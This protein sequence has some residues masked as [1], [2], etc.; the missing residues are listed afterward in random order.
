MAGIARLKKELTEIEKNAASSGVTAAPANGNM[1]QWQGKLKGPSG[2]AYEGGE[3]VVD[4]V[5]PNDYPFSP[6]K[7]KFVTR[8]YH[9]NISSQTGAICLDTLGKEWSPAL[10]IRTALLS[11]AALLSAPEPND[12]QDAVVASQY[13]RDR[14]AFE[15]TARSWAEMYAGAPPRAGGGSSSSAS[16]SSSNRAPAPAVVPIPAGMDA[17][18]VGA[19]EAMGFPRE[20]VIDALRRRGQDV[21]AALGVLLG[22]GG[23]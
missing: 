17:G 13:K 16:S 12:P 9:P 23:R 11:L 7:M 18:K 14:A 2:T 22:D 21:D 15:A 1:S 19:L 8:V 20:A 6:P 5:I 4:I 10:T 3:F